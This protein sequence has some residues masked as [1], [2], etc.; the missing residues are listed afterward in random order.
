[1]GIASGQAGIHGAHG[2]APVP[3]TAGIFI[4]MAGH[5]AA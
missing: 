2:R 3:F 5:P 4:T 1:L